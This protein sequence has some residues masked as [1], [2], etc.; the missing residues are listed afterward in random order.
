M[1]ESSVTRIPLQVSRN[2]VVASIQVDLSDNVLRQFQADLLAMLE[3]SGA[4]AVILD[5]SGVAVMDLD[6]FEALRRTMSMANLM[7]AK[8]IIAGLQP[9]VVSS[10]VEL[11]ANVGDVHAALNLDDAFRLVEEGGHSDPVLD[12]GREANESEAAPSDSI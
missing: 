10:L 1:M 5:V 7:G 8:P 4:S 11:E 6:D 3:K 12:K 2:C 9:G